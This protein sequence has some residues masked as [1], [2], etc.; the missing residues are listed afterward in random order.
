M[1]WAVRIQPRRHFPAFFS[2]NRNDRIEIT[3]CGLELWNSIA[4]DKPR[5]RGRFDTRGHGLPGHDRFFHSLQLDHW[6]VVVSRVS[7]CPSI[8]EFCPQQRKSKDQGPQT[9][10]N[11]D[12]PPDGESIGYF[13]GR[14]YRDRSP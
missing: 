5:K 11:S 9:T 2:G 7:E 14:L 8:D 10:G 3:L 12:T 13:G 1:F 4:P 6:L